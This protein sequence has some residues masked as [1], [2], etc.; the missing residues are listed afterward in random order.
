MQANGY[1]QRFEKACAEAVACMLYPEPYPLLAMIKARS[2]TV[3]IFT[4]ETLTEQKV[5]EEDD[6]ELVEMS[7]STLQDLNIIVS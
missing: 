6:N 4:E 5:E 2:V 3:A 1:V 7:P